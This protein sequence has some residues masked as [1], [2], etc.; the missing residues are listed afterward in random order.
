MERL[1]QLSSHLT[2]SNKDSNSV[3]SIKSKNPDD[4]VVVAA[5]RTPITKGFKGSFKNLHSEDLL[6]LLLREFR[7]K[8]V[9]DFGKLEDIACGNVLAPGAGSNE[10]RAATLAAGVPYQVPLVGI[11]RQCSSGLMSVNHIANQIKAGQ[12]NVGLAAGSE[13]MTQYYGTRGLPKISDFLLGESPEAEKCLIPMGITNENL[14]AKFSI[15][16]PT[17]DRFA[18]LS[19]AKAEKAIESGGFQNEILAIPVKD[20]TTGEVKYVS[21]DEGVRRGTDYNVLSKLKPAFKQDGTTH[22]GNSSQV[23]DGAAIVL[24]ARREAAEQL[25]LPIM[26]KYVA[27]QVIGVPPEIMGVGPA[28]AIPKLLNSLNLTHEDI[29][30]FEINEAFAAQCFYSI[31]KVGIPME[32]V[33]P[34]GGAIALGH[35]LG[36]TGA[37]LVATVLNELQRGQVGVTSMCVGSGMGAA[38]LFVKE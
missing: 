4:V 23:S 29:D 21:Q 22:A 3:Q 33:N 15:D 2:G 35:P 25:Q 30:I 16:R 5:Y 20:E 13:S 17:Q 24:L 7:K 12:I 18:A 19:Y 36:C 28:Y 31:Q 27:T 1:S 26:G 38:A 34:K 9:I 14:A 32:K 8:D 37:R 11:N 10:H 6:Y